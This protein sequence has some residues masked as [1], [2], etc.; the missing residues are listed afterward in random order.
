MRSKRWKRRVND[1]LR[2][3]LIVRIAFGDA[4][5]VSGGRKTPSSR[6]RFR[7]DSR[8]VTRVQRGIF[9]RVAQFVVDIHDDLEE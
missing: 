9:D 2:A 5:R 6:S 8:V 7:R 1:R 3:D 4:N